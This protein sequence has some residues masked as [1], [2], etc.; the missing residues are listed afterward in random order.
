MDMTDTSSEILCGLQ[1]GRE[2]LRV[3]ARTTV[4]AVGMI[5]WLRRGAKSTSSIGLIGLVAIHCF[6]V[7]LAG[8]YSKSLFCR[9]SLA[10]LGTSRRRLLGFSIL[11]CASLLQYIEAMDAD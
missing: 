6:Y 1:S 8:V 3:T 9:C 11:V 10:S 2:I 4:A 7:V 5:T